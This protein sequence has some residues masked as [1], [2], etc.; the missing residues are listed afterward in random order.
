[1]TPTGNKPA[2]A[3]VI[4]TMDM[5]GAENLAV[6]IANHLAS[7]GFPAH[8]IVLRGPGI[9]SEKISPAVSTHYLDFQRVT[10]ANPP[11]FALSLSRGY[12]RL[13]AAARE[14]GIQVAQT[15][16]PG[17]N[18]M[19]LLLAWRGVCRVLPTVHNN[20]EF[21]Y[22]EKDR[23]LLQT[24]RKLAYRR[25]VRST[26]GVIAVSE[27]ARTNLG[28]ELGLSAAELE[29]IMVAT[30]AVPE[31]APMAGAT[32]DQV[33]ARLGCAPDQTMLLAA[34]RLTAQKNFADLVKA[35][36][37]LHREA[38]GFRLVIAGEGEQRQELEQLIKDHGLGAVVHL[39]GNLTRLDQAMQAADVFVMSSLWE[40][41]PLVLLEAMAAGLPVAAY[42]IDGIREVVADGESG[43]LCPSG[44]TE[45]LA[46]HLATLVADAEKRRKMGAAGR[47]II[48]RD[49][50]F[51]RYM[52]DLEALYLRT[53]EVSA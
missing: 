36:A 45:A 16:L 50:S 47:E 1:V 22:G 42:G 46:R 18:F 12:R 52:D 7:D 29:R 39:P 25:L 41:L 19:G 8:L 51:R 17:A 38:P 31:P 10:V 11:G 5:G 23:R 2:V 13:A 37:I 27:E 40:G 35:S 48:R 20:Q 26:S 33:R 4:E 28:H 34:G 15:H 3:Q 43:L 53:A 30:N 6:H 21:N 32:R 24:L 49:Y 14:A 44:D 9:L